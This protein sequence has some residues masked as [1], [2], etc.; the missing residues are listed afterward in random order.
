MERML[1]GDISL[2]RDLSALQVLKIT[3]IICLGVE[4]AFLETFHYHSKGQEM[5]DS[6]EEDLLTLL[7]GCLQFIT[8]ALS[9]GEGKVLVHC[10]AGQSRSCAVAAAWVHPNIRPSPQPQTQTLYQNP[11]H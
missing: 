5:M 7:P 8:E 10:V 9:T 6:P 4:P 3:H 11:S 2:A 1:I